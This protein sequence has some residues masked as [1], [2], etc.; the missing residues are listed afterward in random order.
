MSVVT[1][2]IPFSKLIGN[3]LKANK[4]GS[5]HFGGTLPMSKSKKYGNCT[6]D[7]EVYGMENLFVVDSSNFPSIPGTTV[8]LLSMANAYRIAKKSL[9]N[10]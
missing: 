8:A 1:L 2:C 5:W 3:I 6:V 7:G 4:L 10:K 9:K